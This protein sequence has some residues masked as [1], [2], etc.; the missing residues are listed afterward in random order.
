LEV[1]RVETLVMNAISEGMGKPDQLGG[2]KPVQ[3]R[4]E[5]ARKVI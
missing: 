4:E 1:R 5:E 3:P 2:R